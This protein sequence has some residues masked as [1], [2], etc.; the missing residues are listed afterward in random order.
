MAINLNL[1]SNYL[2][3]F[4]SLSWIAHKPSLIP[5]IGVWF[6]AKRAK[7]TVT[8][9]LTLGGQ[10]VKSVDQYKYLG[11]VLDTELSNDKDIQRQLRCS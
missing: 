1:F 10:N 8:P 7:S 3:V 11:T 4:E 2:F 6:K 5:V 9:V